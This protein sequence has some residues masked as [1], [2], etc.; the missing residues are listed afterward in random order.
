MNYH[1]NR[2]YNFHNFLLVM[3]C[4]LCFLFSACQWNLS[5]TEADAESLAEKGEVGGASDEVNDKTTDKTSDEME[6]IEFTVCE[7]GRLPKELVS[8]IEEKKAEPF[9]LT[10]QTRDYT[11]IVV[12]YGAQPRGGLSVTVNDLYELKGVIHIDTNLIGVAGEEIKI[13][14]MTYP[15]VAV[16]CERKDMMVVYE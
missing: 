2:T 5:G 11:Y 15:Y 10:F 14:G 3:I 1:P 4:M 16:R 13:D 6:A 9:R 8:I 7:E 12:G